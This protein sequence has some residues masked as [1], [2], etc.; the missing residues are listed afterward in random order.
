MQVPSLTPLS[1]VVPDYEGIPEDDTAEPSDADVGH[2]TSL[3]E[4]EEAVHGGR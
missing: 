1:L 3:A 4:V 2:G